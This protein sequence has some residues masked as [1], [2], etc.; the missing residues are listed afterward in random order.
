MS[1]TLIRDGYTE[2]TPAKPYVPYQPAYTYTMTVIG[3][4]TEGVGVSFSEPIP[5]GAVVVAGINLPSPSG[6]SNPPVVEVSSGSSNG[7]SSISVSPVP[8]TPQTFSALWVLSV[9]VPAQ[10]EQLAV[11]SYTVSVPP[12]GWIS[13]ARSAGSIASGWAS[14]NVPDAVSGVVIGFAEYSEPTAGYG[15]IKH[16]LRFAGGT[17]Y[18]AR[19]NA[20]LGAYTT[21]D[22]FKILIEQDDVVVQK[23]GSDLFTE[24]SD[25]APVPLFLSAVLYDVGDSV[26]NPMMQFVGYGS[27]DASLGL[28]RVTASE[29]TYGD[30]ASDLPLLRVEAGTGNSVM[31]A[32]PALAGL[33]SA[34]AYAQSITVL[35]ALKTT[36]YGGLP[37]GVGANTLDRWLPALAS[38][39]LGLSLIHI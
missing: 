20:S 34:Q 17:V 4:Y 1:N 13:F 36:S 26:D 35:D 3:T 21:T 14:F 37:P 27:V 25:Y 23:N 16:G 30:V 19:T 11:P 9:T 7:G 15:H 6:G 24:S 31:R 32:L 5:A 2:L 28:M 29:D 10:P 33:S 22:S 18:N 38:A 12:P 39:A 8:G